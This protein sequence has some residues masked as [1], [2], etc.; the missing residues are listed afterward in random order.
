MIQRSFTYIGLR[1]LFIN[2]IYVRYNLL[3]DI[4]Y[5][6]EILDMPAFIED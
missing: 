4:S 1:G 6:E 2:L 3:S 5:R